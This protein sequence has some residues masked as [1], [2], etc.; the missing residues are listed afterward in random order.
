MVLQKK[1]AYST[2]FL[3]LCS[4]F[5]TF[6]LVL[7]PEIAF[8]ASVDGLQVWWNIVF[9]A[10][11]PFFIFSQVL[12]GLGVVHFLGVLL[13]P[14][15]RP[16]FNV[17]GSGA[18]VMAMGLAS[19]FPIGAVLTAKLRKQ[20]LCSKTEGE[21]LM[22]FVNT[23][24]PLFMFGAVAVGMMGHPEAGIAIALAHY[25]ST[26]IVGIGM[27]F[28]RSTDKSNSN[29]KGP[30]KKSTILLRAVKAL[31]EA[32]R[33]DNRPFGQ[34]LGDAVQDSMKTQA[35]IGG[36]IMLFSVIIAILQETGAADSLALLISQLLSIIGLN[37]QLAPA[38]IS[39]FFEIDLGC[40]LAGSIAGA[41]E[42]QIIV[43]STIIAWSGLSVHAQVAS[44]ISD[45]DLSIVP[46]ICARFIH[47]FLAGACA[48]LLIGPLSPL[49]N[50][51]SKKV[52]IPVFFQ[53]TPQA[54]PTFWLHR[55]IVLSRF[56]LIFVGLLLIIA[57]TYNSIGT[58]K[59]KNFSRLL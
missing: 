5:I 34:L 49:L 41:L 24:D 20:K 16:L 15:M 40:Q 2:F 26:I 17:P 1:T 12:I 45:T 39:G 22:G 59:R 19:G 21:R 53:H 8:K 44:I 55:T 38:L 11:L 14:I 4:L 46:Y 23:A 43:I 28:Y 7:Y 33:K 57:V 52:I 25:L 54:T 50:V 35:L 42:Q 56:S 30:A 6:S 36:F 29:S 37:S 27:R 13:E 48:F 3:A 18:F 9:P 32:R 51:T 47:A 31:E 10:L 58:R